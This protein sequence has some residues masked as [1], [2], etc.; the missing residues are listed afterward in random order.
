HYG[1]VLNKLRPDSSP[2][3]SPPWVVLPSPV[4][5]T[6]VSV[7]HGQT[8]GFL[9]RE[10]DPFCLHADPAAPG[11]RLADPQTA[12]GLDPARLARP[13]ALLAAVDATH[14]LVDETDTLATK[15]RK[16]MLRSY[17]GSRAK[18]AFDLGAEPASVRERYGW[19]TFGQSCLLARRLVEHGVKLVTVNMFDTVFNQIT[20]D[21]HANGGNLN[22]TLGDYKTTSSPHFQPSLFPLPQC[23]VST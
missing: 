16:A 6:G 9:G 13:D 4:G 5:N 15:V 10:H 8:G 19:N 20:W 14:R 18:R 21:C 3:A 11:F 7:S 1:A 22:S 23:F 12:H 2:D 17:F